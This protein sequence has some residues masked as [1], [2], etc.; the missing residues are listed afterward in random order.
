MHTLSAVTL[1]G[2]PTCCPLGHAD[3]VQVVH[4][5]CP[6][7]AAKF[8]PAVQLVHT[9]APSAADIVPEKQSVQTVMEFDPKTLE[10]LPF[11]QFVQTD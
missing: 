5:V 8:V 7:D 11:V 10:N 1:Q 9:D 2:I 4:T 6:L 3:P